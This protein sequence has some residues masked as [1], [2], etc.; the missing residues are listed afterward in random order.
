MQ[1][2]TL[3]DPL[4]V[5]EVR[6]LGVVDEDEVDRAGREPR[7]GLESVDRLAA[8]SES[9]DDDR[10]PIA[11]I[12]VIPDP[13]SDHGVRRVELDGHQS[14]TLAHRPRDPERAVAAVRAELEHERGIVRRT[15]ASRI[16]PF[17]SPTLIM[18]LR[19]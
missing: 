10:H 18:K 2:A 6:I 8:V 5:G 12:G 13:A 4:E 9:S 3:D 11:D 17:S 14:P 19:W 15:A 1:P 7:V 16:S